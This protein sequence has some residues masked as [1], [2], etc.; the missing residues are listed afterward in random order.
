MRKQGG[1]RQHDDQE[2][3]LQASVSSTS[4]PVEIERGT[5]I[6]THTSDEPKISEVG[7]GASVQDVL[8]QRKAVS[9]RRGGIGFTNEAQELPPSSADNFAQLDEQ[10]TDPNDLEIERL[11]SRFAPQTGRVAE[12]NEK[13][14][15]DSAPHPLLQ[16][17]ERRLMCQGW[18]T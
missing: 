16:L 5:S 12:A 17:L 4:P 2:A 13:H 7:S 6:Y 3:P 18:T 8:R 11:V 14:M 1:P 9:R 10:V 15:Y